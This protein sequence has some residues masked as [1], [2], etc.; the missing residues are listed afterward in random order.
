MT[1]HRTAA[2]V[3]ALT[4]LSTTVAATLPATAATPASTPGSTPAARAGGPAAAYASVRKDDAARAAALRAMATPRITWTRC[5]PGLQCGT[6]EVPLD[7]DN[8]A[9]G[10]T[11]LDVSRR[12][13]DK[14]G[15][16]IGSLFTNPGGPGGPA[17]QSVPLFAQLLGPQVRAR[18]DIIGVGPRG[19]EGQDLAR[20]VGKPGDVMPQL[21]E[22]AFPLWDKEFEEHFAY[23]RAYRKTCRTNMPRILQHMS[24][25][26]TARDMDLARRA[27]GDKQLS[28]YGIS[29]G[30][31]LGETYA[32]LFPD[33]VR[34]LV[35]DGVLD[36]V[37]W[38]TGRG[39][40][41]RTKPV[42]ERL[43][44]HKGAQEALMSAFAE[45]ERV[46]T[47]RCAEAK[48][49]RK[50]WDAILA[51]L[52]K[53]PVDLGDGN[54][55]RYDDV[56]GQALRVL[57]S[58]DDI[59]MLM[60]LIHQLREQIAPSTPAT[61]RAA[62]AAPRAGTADVV[63]RFKALVAK[64]DRKHP[65]PA[66]LTGSAAPKR[67]HRT[68]GPS[69]SLAPA[70][71]ASG[72]AAAAEPEPDAPVYDAGFHGVLC[73]DSVNPADPRSFIMAD[74]RTKWEAPGFGPAWL[75][76]ASPCPGWPGM[77]GD[78]Y[79]GPF[80]KKTSAPVLIIGN[81]HDP[82]TPYSGAVAYRKLLPTSRLVTLRNGFGHGALGVSGCVDKVRTQYLVNRLVPA[83]DVTCNPDHELFTRLD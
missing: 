62:A 69:L 3:I 54:Y 39:N 13:A 45:C 38:T 60:Q 22:H 50:D 23:D 32:A 31:F 33:K 43:L 80:T 29:Y 66:P 14:P 61:R 76:A 65:V 48:T 75:W 53:E 47:A 46:G 67:A 81:H 59:P 6:L 21:S 17:T 51:K 74:R 28:Y 20:C 83:A 25:A 36:P 78:A 56:I 30:S 2:A 73:S 44:S 49:V 63:K 4:T 58:P 55:L 41:A 57:Y 7:Y 42:T 8:P 24:T 68:N 70:G 15:N 64:V 72:A 77:S 40:E 35:V 82:A 1:R 9:L 10:T 16:R 18:F 37:A 71:S 34:A 52:S 12:P 11:K 26:D 19:I 79:R 27:L 5:G